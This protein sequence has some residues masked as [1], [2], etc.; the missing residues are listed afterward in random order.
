MDADGLPIVG[1]GINLAEVTLILDLTVDTHLLCQ[2]WIWNGA[3]VDEGIWYDSADVSKYYSDKSALLRT[4]SNS[5]LQQEANENCAR[6]LLW[7]QFKQEV[8]Q[9]KFTNVVPDW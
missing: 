3:S 9:V 8:V 7:N 2:C 4:S 5:Q 6:Q 1:R